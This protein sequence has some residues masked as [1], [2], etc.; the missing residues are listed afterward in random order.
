MNSLSSAPAVRRH[1]RF[2]K[3]PVIHDVLTLC[4][5]QRGQ[6]VKLAWSD[7]PS[8]LHSISARGNVIAFHYPNAS[9]KFASYCNPG[10][11]LPATH[12]AKPLSAGV[13]TLLTS[14]N[15]M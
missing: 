13:K 3:T 7:K 8:R 14:A 1:S 4:V 15:V 11:S 6:W 2:V 10:G 12:R 9:R 5:Y